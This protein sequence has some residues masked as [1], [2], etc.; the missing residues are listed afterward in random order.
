MTAS[1]RSQRIVPPARSARPRASK[2]G[3]RREE[4]D[5]PAGEQERGASRQDEESAVA[6]N[7]CRSGPC[8]Q[9]EDPEHEAHEP[10]PLLVAQ[11]VRELRDEDG[12]VDGDRGSHGER[13]GER[14]QR[15]QQVLGVL[16]L[17]AVQAGREEG[18]DAEEPSPVDRPGQDDCRGDGAAGHHEESG[19]HPQPLDAEGEEEDG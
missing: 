6:A 4:E 17:H 9:D 1:P 12:P 3:S 18:E 15:E 14:A 11:L 7:E 19:R 5:F 2:R 8:R 10:E 13:H 16:H